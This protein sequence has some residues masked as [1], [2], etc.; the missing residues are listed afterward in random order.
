[1]KNEETETFNKLTMNN[2]T[3][4]TKQ[5]IPT[6]IPTTTL[7]SSLR[8]SKQKKDEII[9]LEKEI[10]SMGIPEVEFRNTYQLNISESDTEKLLNNVNEFNVILNEPILCT[11]F[12][13]YLA[14]NFC[15]E[16]L[17]FWKDVEHYRTITD[18]LSL[19]R[20]SFLCF[21]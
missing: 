5:T 10:K 1:M 21:I 14:R 12:R 9:K 2:N 15:S 4:N 3:P 20:F 13:K 8:F 17:L 18:T 6:T 16:N 19:N 11:G 7:L